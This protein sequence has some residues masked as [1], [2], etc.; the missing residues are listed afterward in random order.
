MQSGRAGGDT[1]E[2]WPNAEQVIFTIPTLQI[3]R[4]LVSD[5]GSRL[6]INEAI[7]AH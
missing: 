7:V 2:P 1:Q 6:E 3:G 5:T 4:G